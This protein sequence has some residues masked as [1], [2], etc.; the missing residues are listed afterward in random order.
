ML[1]RTWLRECTH[2]SASDS[3]LSSAIALFMRQGPPGQ[4]GPKALSHYCRGSRL[5]SGWATVCSVST[6]RA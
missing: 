2:N 4:E 6:V 5:D 1:I 3:Q